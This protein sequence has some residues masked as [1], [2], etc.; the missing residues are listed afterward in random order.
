MIRKLSCVYWDIIT[1]MN[2]LRPLKIFQGLSMAKA[3]LLKLKE[4]ISKAVWRI[5]KLEA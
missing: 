2:I 4:D 1:N 3:E 5:L